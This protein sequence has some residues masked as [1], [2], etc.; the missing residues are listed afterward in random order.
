M[1]EGEEP[2]EEHLFGHNVR[3]IDSFTVLPSWFLALDLVLLDTFIILCYY[4]PYYII[5]SEQRY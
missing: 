2:I 5:L 3:M 1:L 4:V